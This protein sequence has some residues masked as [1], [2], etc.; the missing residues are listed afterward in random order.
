[1]LARLRDL[2]A[3]LSHTAIVRMHEFLPPTLRAA[4]VQR[5]ASV[6]AIQLLELVRRRARQHRAEC[7]S[8]LK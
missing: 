5:R 3:G 1:M 7:K 6:D 8:A 4:T 2:S